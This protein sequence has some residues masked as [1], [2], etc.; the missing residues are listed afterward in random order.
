VS[1]FD[2]AVPGQFGAVNVTPSP[3]PGYG[4]AAYVATSQSNG[5][6]QATVAVLGTNYSLNVTGDFSESVA[7]S[8]AKQLEG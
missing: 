4:Q 1:Q 2:I 5:Q 7:E 3:L 8:L 6:T